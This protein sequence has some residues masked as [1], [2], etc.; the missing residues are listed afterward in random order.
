MITLAKKYKS[1]FFDADDTLFDYPR[2]ERAAL[3]ACLCEF[4][5]HTEP[6]IFFSTYRRHNHDLWQA[7][8]RGETDQAALRVERFRRLAAEL[9]IPDLPLDRLSTFYLE[10]LSSQPQLLPGA[11]ATVRAL[12]K[13]FPLALVTNGIAAVQNRRFAASPITPYFQAVVISEEVGIAKPDPRIFA[14]ALQKI[15]VEAVDVL[16]VGDSVSSDMAAARNA[17]MDFCWL[18]PSGAPVPAGQTPAHI[19]ASIHELPKLPGL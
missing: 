14:P 16:Y 8:E 19:I 1:V 2:A 18:N 9:H 17:G 7:F 6:E 10:A 13:K 12:A 5:I 15:G 4:R 3:Q 11:L